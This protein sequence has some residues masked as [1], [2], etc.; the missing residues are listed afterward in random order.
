VARG[1]LLS[2]DPDQASTWIIL[3]EAAATISIATALLGLFLAVRGT[4]FG[5]EDRRP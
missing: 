3:I 2:F 5:S 1:S 4:P